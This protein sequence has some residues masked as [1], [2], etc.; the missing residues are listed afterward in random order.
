MKACIDCDK[1]IEQTKSPRCEPC[2]KQAH[3]LRRQ[4]IAKRSYEKHKETT[5]ARVSEFRRRLD[6][7][8]LFI[9][10]KRRY[11]KAQRARFVAA[12]LT[13]K[14]TPRK[15]VI[16]SSKMVDKAAKIYRAWRREW[17]NHRAPDKC[18][19]AWYFATGKPWNNPRLN[20][21][22][23]FA[24][25]YQL[26][27]EFRAREIIKAQHRKVIRAQRIANLSD[28]TIT[29]KTLG[30]LFAEAK[31]CAYC[32]DPLTSYKQ[33]TAD[34][35]DPLYL[36][37]KHSIDNI[38]IACVSCN[39]SKGKKSLTQWLIAAQPMLN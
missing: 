12:G 15:R 23:K 30:T 39:S 3:K 31:F 22:E 1:A 38:V 26:D 4:A 20:G 2:R 13:I 21:G 16:N 19:V 11:R 7:A 10:R 18:V 32:L 33:K 29:P 34:H 35:V 8:G 6:A 5:K 28:G 9:E 27:N 36:G 25:R 24:V 14:G 17:I 37:G